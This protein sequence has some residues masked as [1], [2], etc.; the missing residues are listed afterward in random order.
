MKQEILTPSSLT[1]SW[2]DRLGAEFDQGYMSDLRNFLKRELQ[3]GKSIFPDQKHWFY[4]FELIDF[5]GVQ[6]VIL[7]Q[8]PYHG[9][10]QAHGLAFS[11]PPGIP[12]PPSLVNI[13]KELWADLQ[14]KPHSSGFLE[15]WSK[16]GVLLLNS[17]LT[18]E[19]GMAASHQN[20]GWERFTDRVIDILSEQ[21]EGLVF[22]L[23]GSYAQKK[24]SRID[25][26]KHLVIESPHP[27]PLSS[28]RGFF[29]SRPFS[30]VNDWFKS[31]GKTQ[32]DWDLSKTN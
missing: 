21:R 7:G 31:R 1:P 30:R 27:S 2:R 32:I 13:Y 8:D 23:W 17:V 29:G 24:G 26:A 22:V 3:S 25:R 12:C 18:V 20:K 10:G 28:Y 4:A 5:D 19:S 6:V 15:S 11:V 14:I 9:D 16:Q